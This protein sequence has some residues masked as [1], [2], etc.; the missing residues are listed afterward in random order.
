[1]RRDERGVWSEHRRQ[2][3]TGL[4]AAF[5]NVEVDVLLEALVEQIA[6]RWDP[7]AHHVCDDVGFDKLGGVTGQGHGHL[8]TG[9]VCA[10]DGD[11]ERDAGARRVLWTG[12]GDDEKSRHSDQYGQSMKVAA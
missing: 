5:S 9:R 7:K 8:D 12:R 2:D 1:M 10:V 3:P 6:K 11:V 4:S